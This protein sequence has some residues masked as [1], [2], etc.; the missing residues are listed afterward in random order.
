MQVTP[1]AALRAVKRAFYRPRH[2]GGRAK[3]KIIRRFHKLYYYSRQRTWENTFWLNVPTAKCPLDLWVYQEI[4]CEIKPD[5]IIE[6][7]TAYGGSALFLASICDQ[8][9]RGQIIT[10]DVVELPGRPEHQ[11]IKYLTGSSTAAEVVEEIRGLI[12]P[13][14]QVM[15]ILDSGHG[16]AH[17]RR[18]LD[19]YSPLVTL[20]SYLI[21]EDTNVNGHPVLPL[22][23]AGPMEALGEFARTRTDFV[24]DRQREK[25]FMTFNPKGYLRRVG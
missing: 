16:A 2:P 22:Y 7:G 19:I 9:N 1:S 10:I 11:R 5:L 14:D 13:D 23:G 4:I 17:V 3:G 6:T 20:G 21:V 18:E 25:F 15:V 12:K 24:P 8:I